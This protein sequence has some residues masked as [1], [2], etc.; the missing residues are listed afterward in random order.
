MTGSVRSRRAPRNTSGSAK[1]RRRC[2]VVG[3]GRIAGGFIAPVLSAAGWEVILVCRTTP[4][5]A[6]VNE[7]GGMLL[8]T[9]G[10]R[11][12]ERWIGGVTALPPDSPELPRQVAT[13]ELL[14]T[15]VGPAALGEVGR[16]LGPLLEA[17]AAAGGGPLNVITFENH[18]R[19]PELLTTGLL[20]TAPSLARSVGGWLGVGGAAVWRCVSRRETTPGGLVLEAN[21]VDECAVDGASLV[22]GVPPGDGSVPGLTLVRAFDD[23]MVEKLWLFNA[24]HAAA[25]YL[26][27]L[28]GHRTTDAALAD[29]ALRAAVGDVVRE[30]QQGL[31]AHLATRPGSV[32]LPRRA[33]ETILAH[34]ADPALRDTVARVGREPRRKLVAGDRLLGPAL[35]C[36]GAGRR[37]TALARAAAAALAYDEPSD[38][39][40]AGLQRELALVG[41]EEVLAA[42]GTLDPGDEL[43]RLVCDQYRALRRGAREEA[44]TC[45]R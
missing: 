34:Y 29:P 10:E 40:A 38:L 11:P 19:A 30:A 3:A 1:H 8:R 7:R 21:A 43:L 33:V 35:A 24:G 25:A 39:Q 36:L 17:R 44:V 42:V 45:A 31:E 26:G 15:A 6:A 27:R 23:R 5:C 14:A 13:A 22:P 37:P 32:P 2:V 16:F 20:A 18:R 41:P 4:V 9:V 28:A 12:S